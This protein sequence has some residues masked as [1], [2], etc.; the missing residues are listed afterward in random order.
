[1]TEDRIRSDVRVQLARMFGGAGASALLVE[2]M[3][4]CSGRARVDMAVICDRL[5]GIE[6]KGPKDDLHRLPGQ[7]NHYSKC[8]DIVVLVVHEELATGAM[9][10]IPSWWGVVTGCEL[11]GSYGYRLTRRPV[12]NKH[13][14]VEA[15]LALLWRDE[16]VL[17]W[18]ALLEYS[19]PSKASKKQL[20]QELIS[21]A[22]AEDL[23]AVGID[24][25]RKRQDWR[26]LPISLS[27][28]LGAVRKGCEADVMIDA[29]PNP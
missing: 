17:L 7:V 16:I 5:I 1:M 21:R 27:P 26:S 24:L 25:L 19:P 23:R 18:S 10:L 15:F 3:E 28:V 29:G 14:D 9:E 11:H 22:R 20:R 2:E 6:I 13:A 4:V 8:F 12:R